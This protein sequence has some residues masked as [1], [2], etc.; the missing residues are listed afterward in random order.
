[1][2]KTG[3][4]LMSLCMALWVIACSGHEDVSESE[5]S[6]YRPMLYVQ[7]NLYGETSDTVN[8]LS[9]DAVCIGTIVRV[10]SQNEPMIHENFTS[11]LL[12]EGSE[13]YFDET[14]L[15][16]V[17]VKLM[18]SPEEQYAVYIIIE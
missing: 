15:D 8:T 3:L 14:S 16:T 10:V 4:F 17:Y 2:K 6:D 7:D 9:D 11:N 13:I 5:L 12:Q 18:D 1:M